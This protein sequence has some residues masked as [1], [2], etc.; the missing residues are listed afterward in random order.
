MVY[1][2]G[3]TGGDMYWVLMI[4]GLADG[5]RVS[6]NALAGMSAANI[7]I[8]QNDICLVMVFMTV[9]GYSRRYPRSG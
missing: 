6:A 8:D 2:V 7:R 9:I 4:V 3:F 1:V 5:T